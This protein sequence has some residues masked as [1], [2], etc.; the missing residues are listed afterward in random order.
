MPIPRIAAGDSV[1]SPNRDDSSLAHSP[2]QGGVPLAARPQPTFR[3]R[4]RQ[5]RL[6]RPS[7]HLLSRRLWF[8][9]S[10]VVSAWS[11]TP[12]ADWMRQMGPGMAGATPAGDP[13]QVEAGV[14]CMPALDTSSPRAMAS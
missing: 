3:G 1:P 5:D 6:K 10:A 9:L 8:I 11:D 14:C 12:L 2:C 7:T 13:A 4:S